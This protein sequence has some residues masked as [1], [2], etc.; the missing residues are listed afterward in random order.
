DGLD[1][2]RDLL[3]DPAVARF[4]APAHEC[5]EL[6]IEGLDVLEARV[7]DLEAHVARRVALREP[8]EDELADPL[9]RHLRDAA[10]AERGLEL[11]DE[12]VD[13]VPGQRL[14]GALS[15]GARELPAVELL[16]R[17]VAL[18]D[19]DARGLA[20]L[21]GGESRVAAVADAPAADRGAV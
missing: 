7:D 19:L 5:R 9:R 14:R 2:E 18:Q 8:F 21:E 3:G 17:A 1:G 10:L 12:P 13:L 20:A 16:A 15:N 11:V 4:L 6:L